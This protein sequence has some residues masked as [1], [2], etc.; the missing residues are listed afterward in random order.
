MASF[1]HRAGSKKVAELADLLPANP[2]DLQPKN[3]APAAPLTREEKNRIQTRER[4]ARAR[5]IK[6]ATRVN[7]NAG[8]AINSQEARDKTAKIVGR[9]NEARSQ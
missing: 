4:M 9:R 3:A 2:F 5:A 8:Y 6:L 7:P 1:I